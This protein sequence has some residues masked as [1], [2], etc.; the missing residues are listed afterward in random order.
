[1]ANLKNIYT[2]KKK[3]THHTQKKYMY[4]PEKYAKD[5]NVVFKTYQF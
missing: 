2:K 5:T 1:M 3:N 4:F